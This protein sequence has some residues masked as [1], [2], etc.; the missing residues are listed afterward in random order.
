MDEF[1]R[2]DEA[3]DPDEELLALED[4]LEDNRYLPPPIEP[5]DDPPPIGRSWRFDFQEGRFVTGP[6]SRGPAQTFEDETLYVWC[7]KALHTAS[8]AHAIY[9]SDYG[10]RE[11]NRWVGRSLTSADFAQISEDI[12]AALTF[13]PRISDVIDFEFIQDDPDEDFLEV[14]FTVVRDDD[15]TVTLEGVP[16][17]EGA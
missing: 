5:E 10:M 6:T 17:G 3:P 14:N 15:S 16:V 9:A 11:A 8:E 7:E 12:H 13:H 1:I 2:P 4:A